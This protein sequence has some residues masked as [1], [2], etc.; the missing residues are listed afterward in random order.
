MQQRRRRRKRIDDDDAINESSIQDAK[1]TI[2]RRRKPV[3]P[4]PVEEEVPFEGGR[5]LYEPLSLH[6]ITEEEPEEPEEKVKKEKPQKRTTKTRATSRPTRREGSSKK[7][8]EKTELRS[9]KPRDLPRK[10]TQ[11]LTDSFFFDLIQIMEE[12]KTLTIIKRRNNQWTLV[13]ETNIVIQEERIR[14]KGKAYW[15]EVLSP[16]YQANKEQW[17]MLSGDDKIA[18]AVDSGAEWIEHS[19][20]RINV[21]R[22]ADAYRRTLDIKKYKP[23]YSTLL[24]R[25]QIRGK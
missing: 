5:S 25:K 8:V 11:I 3:E 21:M 12:G 20:P 1:I 15:D 2:K 17:D 6:L 13:S 23:E 16:E 22:C 18:L 19:T 4:E 10:I 24:S 14:L 9:E 7:K